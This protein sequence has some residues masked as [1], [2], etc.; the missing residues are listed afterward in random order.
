MTKVVPTPPTAT[1]T[2]MDRVYNPS[3]VQ[4]E[5]STAS[6]SPKAN[7][8][9]FSRNNQWHYIPVS[10]VAKAFDAETKKV[11]LL[12]TRIPVLIDGFV[13]LT[14]RR[15]VRVT[16]DDIVRGRV[17]KFKLLSSAEVGRLTNVGRTEA[18]SAGD[19]SSGGAGES[20]DKVS[21]KG[22]KQ[23]I[24]TERDEGLSQD[25][26]DEDRSAADLALE[27]Q[28]FS[29]LFKEDTQALRRIKN[30]AHTRQLIEGCAVPDTE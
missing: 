13:C 20:P 19:G 1:Q 2:G 28:M 30:V 22:G 5:M 9:A 23:T 8:F 7:Y 18:T 24:Q 12:P 27:E 11:V 17:C 15:V 10:G 29:L 6:F 3:N 25:T 21:R 26:W 14:N 16:V 4:P